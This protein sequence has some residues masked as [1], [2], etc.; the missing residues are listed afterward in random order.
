MD[1]DWNSILMMCYIFFF[2][3]VA[4]IIKEKVGIF[5]T[6][7][8]PT[9]L[10]AGFLGLVFGPGLL[11]KYQIDFFNFSLPLGLNYDYDFYES[12]VFYF[13]IIGFVSLSLTERESK[14]NNKS[15]DCGMFIVS[16]YVFQAL[17]GIFV[18]FIMINTFWPDLFLG[19]GLLLPLAFGQGPG[20]ANSIGE[21]WD[22]N[23]VTNFAQQFG[24]TLA[25]TGF[26]IGGIIGLFL[27]NYFIKK[28]KLRPVNLR[29]V[30]GLKT[31]N[32]NFSTLNEV[33]FYDNLLVQIVWLSLIL[34][35]TYFVSLIFY[36]ALSPL[37]DIGNTLSKLILGF[38]YLFGVFIALGLR[39]FLRYLDSRGHRTKP[40][41]DNYI[42]RNISA[43]SFNVMITAS[44]MAIKIYVIKDYL[45]V[46][47]F[48]ALIGAIC[49]LL[50]VVLFGKFVF[51]GKNQI[52]YVITLFGM[53][54]GVAATGLALLRGID[55]ELETDTADNVV[56]LGSAIAAPIGIPMMIVLSFPIIA[57]T[58]KQ[59]F[60]YY[61][62][63]ISLIGYLALLVGILIFRVKRRQK[64]LKNK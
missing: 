21:S 15:L 64:R 20:L 6:I 33:N 47:I 7:I 18:I 36:N 34:L 57:F 59:N 56:V 50:Y 37:G 8:I 60:Y 54:T 28:Y 1:A 58:T 4:K 45:H 49:T 44:V 61:L 24:L 38:S 2:M 10:L 12:L 9:S 51:K 14:Q 46:L 53:L 43:F 23:N 22:L 13:M 31:K 17:I 32:V 5:K 3:F 16:T 25:T 40:L 35:L 41:I 55:P 52:H 42:M 63:V 19:L 29:D 30:K 39:G 11:G 62:T 27:L 26:L 48:V